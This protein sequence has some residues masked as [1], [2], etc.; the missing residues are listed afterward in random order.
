[1]IQEKILSILHLFQRV[2]SPAMPRHLIIIALKR[3]CIQRVVDAELFGFG[4]QT[5][6]FTDV[7][8]GLL[9]NDYGILQ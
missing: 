1:M 6:Q 5:K 2:L 4:S 7:F 3:G 9:I 8:G